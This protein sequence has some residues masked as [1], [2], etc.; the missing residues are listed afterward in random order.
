MHLFKTNSAFQR[1]FHSTRAAFDSFNERLGMF[2]QTRRCQCCNVYSI[3]STK[4]TTKQSRKLCPAPFATNGIVANAII[5]LFPHCI[6]D[7]R[8]KNKYSSDISFL[9]KQLRYCVFSPKQTPMFV[10]QKEQTHNGRL[11]SDQYYGINYCICQRC[12]TVWNNHEYNIVT[13]VGKTN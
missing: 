1:Q 3:Q 2:H 8:S 11:S 6:Q 12:V 4:R 5:F 10:E 9:F 13:K 7:I